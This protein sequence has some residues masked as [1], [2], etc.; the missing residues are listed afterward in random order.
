MIPLTWLYVPGDRPDRFA[1]AV[2]SGADVVII[3]LEDAVAPARKQLALEET[4]AFLSASHPVPVQVRIS[5]PD[6]LTTLLGLPGLSGVRLPK[7]EEPVAPV[8]VPV[9]GLIESARGLERA[10]EIA[11]SCA[12]AGSIGLGEADLG[13]DLGVSD[14]A[15]FAWARSRIVVAARAAGLP[16]PAMS[17]YPHVSDLDGLAAS[18]LVGRGLG[19]L[20][21]A[22]IH[23]RQLPV[24]D[25]AFRPTADEVDRARLLLERFDPAAGT[26][27][28]PDGRFVDVAMV[29]AARRTMALAGG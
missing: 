28:L 3:D 23:P 24:I 29:A 9:H 14:D 26:A 19:L 12:P 13:A 22:A 5:A 20:G 11:S 7:V 10:A 2:G 1:S 16:P 15:G 25:R 4:A 6:Q 27:V 8:G 18:C 21:R 17:V